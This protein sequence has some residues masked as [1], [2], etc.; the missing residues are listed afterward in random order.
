METTHRSIGKVVEYYKDETTK[1]G[2]IFDRVDE[3]VEY[4]DGTIE[5]Y[6]SYIICDSQGNAE[7]VLPNKLKRVIKDQNENPDF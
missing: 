6:T 2:T 5:V 7:S 3:P 1:I 4:A